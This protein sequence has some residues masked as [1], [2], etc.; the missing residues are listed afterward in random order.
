MRK[1]RPGLT[2]LLACLV[3]FALAPTAAAQLLP[4]DPIG[5]I[6]DPLGGGGDS[7]SGSGSGGDPVGDTIGGVTDTIGGKDGS[8]EPDG[9]ADGD[10]KL[11]EEVTNG[12]KDTVKN[13]ET[14]VDE[15]VNDPSG[16]IG[17]TIGNTT[18]AAT[19][20]VNDI[21]KGLTS[22]GGKG[23]KEKNASRNN[24]TSGSGQLAAASERYHDKVFA[25][26][27]AARQA[28]AKN[29]TPST[30]TSSTTSAESAETGVIQTI[31]RVAAEAVEQAA[32][33]LLLTLLV[34][35]FLI[36]QNRIDRRD[37]KLALAPLD[38]DQDLLSFT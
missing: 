15:T 30:S 34:G 27:L 12:I 31:G 37:P 36:G 28:D 17:G 23:G 6:G 19:N 24:A 11:V 33:P 32:F 5:S 1:T 13:P 21:S 35:A 4:A 7:G 22:P 29:R 14:K 16:S 25:E 20:D 10:P 26:A 38:S 18:D 2:L 3:I 9:S 8:S